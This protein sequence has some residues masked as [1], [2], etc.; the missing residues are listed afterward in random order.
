MNRIS[1]VCSASGSLLLLTM[2]AHAVC[3]NGHPSIVDEYKGSTA[4]VLATVIGQRDAPEASDGFYLGGIFYRLRIERS[5]NGN[6][7]NIPEVFSENSSSRFP[8]MVGSKYLLFIT[9]QH[10]R[11]LVDYCGNS[12]LASKRIKELRALE[13]LKTEK[14]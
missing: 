13:Q 6:P 11:L 14:R 8:M 12:G 7:G 4:V 2:S 1:S 3:L 9:Y 10:D 5:F